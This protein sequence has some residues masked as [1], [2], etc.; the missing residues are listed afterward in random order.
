MPISEHLRKISVESKAIAD[1]LTAFTPGVN[2]A[3]DLYELFE[4]K[5]LL[6]G[7]A[8]NSFER[9]LALVGLAIGSGAGFRV[10]LE[11]LG[12]AARLETRVANRIAFSA[13]RFFGKNANSAMESVRNFKW[14]NLDKID[15]FLADIA[16]P[17]RRSHI[18]KGDATGGGHLWPSKAS[19]TSFPKTWDG[20]KI[21]YKISDIVIDPK[22]KWRQIT[23]KQGAT[24][25]RK[26]IPVKY[27][28][29]RIKDGI[30]IKIIVQP[31][32]RGIITAFP[33]NIGEIK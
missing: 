26:G 29:V 12:R 9:S 4:G 23:G 19:K 27:E 6:S 10:V 20:D 24:H 3:R 8:L 31:E 33:I 7:E 2:D 13:R 21:M 15:G 32:G 22:T 18:L 28:A 5:D 30:K 16:N 14:K 11:K 17:K 1:V 25:T